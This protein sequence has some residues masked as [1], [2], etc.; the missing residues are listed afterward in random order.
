[1]CDRNLGIQL[2]DMDAGSM[3]GPRICST[4]HRLL[5]ETL[6]VL[7]RWQTPFTMSYH[8]SDLPWDRKDVKC[9]HPELILLETLYSFGAYGR[10]MLLSGHSLLVSR[11]REM[12]RR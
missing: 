3:Q 12:S 4:E 11:F 5:K 10:C 7:D 8:A 1:M 2:E 6:A 9:I